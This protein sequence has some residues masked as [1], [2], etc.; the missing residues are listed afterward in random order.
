MTLLESEIPSH[1]HSLHGADSTP[2]TDPTPVRRTRSRRSSGANRSISATPPALQLAG[3]QR[4]RARGR[5]PAAQQHAAVPDAQLLHR[6]AGRLPAADVAAAVPNAVVLRPI[7]PEDRDLL[8]RIYGST[9]DGGARARPVDGRAEGRVPRDAVRRADGLLASSTPTP[10]RSIVEIDGVPAGR[11]YVQRWPKE[12][13]L[14]DIALLPAFAGGAGDRAHAQAVLRRRRDREDRHHPRRDLRTPRAPSTSA[15]A[16][17]RRASAGCTSS[18]NGS[19]GLG[20]ASVEDG[21]VPHARRVGPD[22]HEEDVE[23]AERLVLERPDVLP[24]RRRRRAP[25][26]QR[27]GAAARTGGVTPREIGRL[28]ENQ[29]DRGSSLATRKLSPTL[30]KKSPMFSPSSMRRIVAQLSPSGGIR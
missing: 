25:E 10:R 28:D 17:S 5:R 14:V 26:D 29:N 2:A 30:S 27:K 19:R 9:R 22:R 20:A 3:R 11:L 13:R 15:S 18:W 6:A 8:C 16:S 7:R 23:P 24:K 4:A 21:L 1:T 12:I